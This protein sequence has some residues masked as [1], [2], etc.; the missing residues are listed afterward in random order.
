M[1]I[2]ASIQL[3]HELPHARVVRAPAR[4]PAAVVEHLPDLGMPGGEAALGLTAE[5]L[6]DAP[7]ADLDLQTGL[8]R[9]GDDL[10]HRLPVVREI[11]LGER[12]QHAGEPA[13]GERRHVGRH[14]TDD[15]A[16]EV[17]DARPRT[18]PANSSSILVA[19]DCTASWADCLPCITFWISPS[20][21]FAPSSAP[22][23]GDGG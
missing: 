15:P 17:G 22:Q 13:L 23:R 6:A 10:A 7:R 3:V 19:S 5:H 8:V 16:A 4:R 18:H 21:M 11:V 2:A 9:A 1:S 20:K 14:V 12:V